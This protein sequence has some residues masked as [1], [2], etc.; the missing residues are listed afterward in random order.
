MGVGAAAVC[1]SAFAFFDAFAWR[2]FTEVDFVAALA[3]VLAA[4]A[5]QVWVTPDDQVTDEHWASIARR[6]SAP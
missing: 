6:L 2:P 1:F 3:A 5:R 4:G